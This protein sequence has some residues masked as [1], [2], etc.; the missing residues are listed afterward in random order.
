MQYWHA[1]I[2]R[3]TNRKVY[4]PVFL[5]C[6]KILRIQQNSPKI[7]TKLAVK[8]RRDDTP[9]SSRGV[10]LR[11]CSEWGKYLDRFK[12][13]S[14]EASF[15]KGNRCLV[16]DRGVWLVMSHDESWWA[17]KLTNQNVGAAP[18]EIDWYRDE[19]IHFLKWWQQGKKCVQGME[20]MYRKHIPG[21][22]IFDDSNTYFPPA[23]FKL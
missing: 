21:S 9:V 15:F 10:L 6:Q 4:T 13:F 14:L 16:R 8:M 1:I 5:A 20:I 3:A 7:A 11:N 18:T 17:G 22:H 23:N 12:Y 2:L 19:F